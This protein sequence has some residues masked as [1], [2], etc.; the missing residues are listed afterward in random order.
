MIILSFESN[1]KA[2]EYFNFILSK[3]S[4]KM[5]MIIFDDIVYQYENEI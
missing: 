5:E 4:I 3:A 1:N 2:R